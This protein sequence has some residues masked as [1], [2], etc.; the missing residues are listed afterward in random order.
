M[1]FYCYGLLE[2]CDGGCFF[3]P[4][5][6]VFS[7]HTRAHSC[8]PSLFFLIWFVLVSVLFFLDV[9][10]DDGISIYVMDSRDCI[11]WEN[12]EGDCGGVG[13]WWWCVWVCVVLQLIK[14][15]VL[16]HLGSGN[17][18]RNVLETSKRL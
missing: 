1:G 10:L 9:V 2:W 14:R 4:K 16:G 8:S 11:L 13:R 12:S 3:G 17:P 7:L 5:I 15:H 18:S 6:N